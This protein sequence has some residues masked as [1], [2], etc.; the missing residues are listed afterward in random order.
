MPF[1]HLSLCHPLLLL[2]PIFPS[3]MI[4]SN[5]VAKVL[6]FQLQHHS[7]QYE[8]SGLNFPQDGLVGYACSPRDSQES[9]PTPQFKSINSS[10]LGFLYSPT[11]TS[12]HDFWKNHSF[13]QMDLCWQ[14]NV[15]AFF[16]VEI[17]KLKAKEL[18]IITVIKLIKL[19][20]TIMQITSYYASVCVYCNRTIQWM[21]DG[22]TQNLS[23]AVVFTHK[24]GDWVGVSFMLINLSQRHK[25]TG[26][27]YRYIHRL[28]YAFPGSTVVKNLLANTGDLDLIPGSGRSP[29]GEHG[30]PPHCSC[31]KNLMD[32]ETWQA[33][34][35]GSP[36]SWNN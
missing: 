9:S 13:G 19:Y 7:F 16:I 11:L 12:I 17:I 8:C 5:K 25:Y 10:V 30:N 21:I 34:V 23:I 35:H 4:F 22:K 31:L 26:Y 15:S 27:I 3:I 6:K 20:S 36:K 1:N 14:S 2:P 32:R 24:K 33:I 18:Y 29:G 28:V